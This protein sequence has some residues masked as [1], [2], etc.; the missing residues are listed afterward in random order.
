MNNSQDQ[1]MREA[2]ADLR[3]SGDS[4]AENL[5]RAMHRKND[6]GESKAFTPLLQIEMTA[7]LKTEWNI[8]CEDISAYQPTM[9]VLRTLPLDTVKAYGVMPLEW[10]AGKLKVA[11]VDPTDLD[12]L[13][14]LQVIS[15][16]LI[17]PIASDRLTL[18][19]MIG[20]FYKNGGAT[21]NNSA[22]T[23]PSSR[24]NQ[25]HESTGFHRGMGQGLSQGLR[26]G[27]SPIVRLVH[28]IISEAIHSGSSD[29]HF[30]PFEREMKVRLRQDGVLRVHRSIHSRSQAEVVSRVK[31]MAN[32]DIA[33]KRRP[34]DGRI[35]LQENGRAV[36]IRVSTL[37]TEYG[38][39]VVLRILDREAV[40]LDLGQLGLDP[41]RFNTLKKTLQLPYGMILITGPTGAGKTTTL[42]SALNLIKSPE[43]NIVTVEDPIEYKLEGIIQT[44]VKTEIN[45]TFANALRTILRQDPNVIMV[46]EIRDRETAEI[47]IRAA[48]T[49]H[50]V[51]STLHTNDAPSAVTRLLDMGI[52]PFLIAS[53]LTLIGAQRLVR[54][55]C[56]H[57]QGQAKGCVY[58]R[59][60]GF[61]GRVGVFEILPVTEGIR[62]LIIDK[63]D[64]GIIR[65]YAEREG[66]LGLREDGIAKVEAGVTIL[67]EVLRETA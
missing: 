14:D 38:E 44:A 55:T 43:R 20:S 16:Y 28:E 57:C 6:E 36:D 39:K 24:S 65:E 7:L 31:I 15:G 40:P 25:N 58:C 56:T 53:A 32:L 4:L 47:A 45:F 1:Y 2:I 26:V 67:E 27:E 19:K 50:L 5:W 23:L 61:A 54:K 62:S 35:R 11:L 30:E 52:E 18:E 22:E 66:M 41:A 48:L 34:Q 17:E 13:A 59:H 51:L 21:K 60:T 10:K 49:G 29:I 8:H 3:I 33:E 63:K 46:G 42:Y 37:P 64:A 12:I 9:D